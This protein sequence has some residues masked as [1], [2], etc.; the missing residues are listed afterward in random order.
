MLVEDDGPGIPDE[1]RARVVLAGVR[2]STARGVGEGLGLSSALR[3]MTGQGGALRVEQRS[4]GGTRVVL[5]WPLVA[6]VTATR[7]IELP[8]DLP[9]L[10]PT[11]DLLVR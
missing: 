5:T 11:P 9:S 8:S 3:A 6:P 7:V 2:G 4:G 10:V 1:E